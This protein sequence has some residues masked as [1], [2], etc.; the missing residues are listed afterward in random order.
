MR[1]SM[2]RTAYLIGEEG[3]N[4]LSGKH[5]A[6]F[7]VGGV[8]GYVAEALGRAGVGSITLVDKDTVS[9]SNINRQIIAT[10]E[11]IGQRKTEVMANRLRSINPDIRVECRDC[12]FLP[13]TADDFDFTGYDYVVDAVDTVTAK[14]ELVKRANEAGVPIISCMGTGNKLDPSRFEIADIAKTTVCPLAKVMRRE[15]KK[16]GIFH[17]KVLYSKEEPIKK[18]GTAVPGSISFVPPVAGLM[19]AGEVIKDLLREEKING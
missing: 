15:L 17:L 8:G 14:L 4:L 12:F 3:V 9:E 13:E 2:E 10:Y 1:E 7:G 11:T 19:I 5:V 18:E 16:R 6:L